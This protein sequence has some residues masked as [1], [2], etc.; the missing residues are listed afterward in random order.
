MAKKCC[1]KCKVP[2]EGFLYAVIAKGL[3]GVNP[4]E[5]RPNVCNKCD[6]DTDVK[7]C[8]CCK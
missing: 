4:S 2:L 7:K 8:G 5:K 6:S 3:F 1:E